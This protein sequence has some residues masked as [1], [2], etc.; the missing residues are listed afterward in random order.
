MESVFSNEGLAEQPNFAPA[1]PVLNSVT[2]D[3]RVARVSLTLPATDADGGSLTGLA[4]CNVFYKDSSFAGSTPDA[5]RA[6]GTPVV[7]VPV[8]DSL[9]GTDVVVSVP[10][11]K[12]GMLY[13]FVATCND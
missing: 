10:D 3:G 13:Y 7:S 12:F 5:E 1:A 6:A 11:L 9:A 8:T 2:F 4:G